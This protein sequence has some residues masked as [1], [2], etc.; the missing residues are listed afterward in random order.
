MLKTFKLGGVHP[1]ENKF[2]A[3]KAIEKL[4]LPKSVFIPVAQHIGAPAQTLVKKGDQV[5]VGQI[6]AKA[7][8]FVSANIHSS[9]SG[10]VKKVDLA[11]A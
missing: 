11:T 6:I 4:A 10:T 2:S 7:G 8:G 5:K 3:N 9:V 1:A